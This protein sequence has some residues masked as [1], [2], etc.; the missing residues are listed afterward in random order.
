MVKT[1]AKLETKY[2][3]PRHKRKRQQFMNKQ[4]TSPMTPKMQ[5]SS[6]YY[7]LAA[8]EPKKLSFTEAFHHVKWNGTNL[9]PALP[10]PNHTPKMSTMML[11][12]V[13]EGATRGD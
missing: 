9:K 13:E 7:V 8:P 6:I 10:Y 12:E 5:A 1:L 2:L 11:L 3:A 4:N